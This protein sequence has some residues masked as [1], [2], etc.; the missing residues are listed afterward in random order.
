MSLKEEICKSPHGRRVWNQEA[1]VL[2]MTNH[3]CHIMKQQKVSRAELACR[4]KKSEK[5]LNNFLDGQGSMPLRQVADVLLALNRR[6]TPAS[7]WAE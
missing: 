4:I 3:I 1:V 2:D 6:L 7:V 5:W